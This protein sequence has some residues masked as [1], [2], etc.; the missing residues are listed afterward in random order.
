MTE[1][2]YEFLKAPGV[3]KDVDLVQFYTK[4]ITECKDYTLKANLLSISQIALD[5]SK[6]IHGMRS[7]PAYY[8]YL[9]RDAKR[10][11]IATLAENVTKNK[12][13]SIMVASALCELT[14]LDVSFISLQNLTCQ[15]DL[16]KAVADLDNIEKDLKASHAAD[17][18]VFAAFYKAKILFHKIKTQP[19]EFYQAG[20]QYLAYAQIDKVDREERSSLAFDLGLAALVAEDIYNFGEL[21]SKLNMVVTHLPA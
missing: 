9:G 17:S 10:A 21:V 11:F 1:A 12:E 14:I 16:D 15:A 5:I 13:A 3:K 6:Q 8:S 20:L 4:M 18:N 7:Q 2:I 19:Q